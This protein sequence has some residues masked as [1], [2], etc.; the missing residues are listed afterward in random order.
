M[1]G[2]YL[3]IPKTLDMKGYSLIQGSV[4]HGISQEMFIF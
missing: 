2:S 4:V 1:L 3:E